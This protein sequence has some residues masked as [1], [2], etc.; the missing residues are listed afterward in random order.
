MAFATVNGAQLFYEISGK[1][2]PIVLIPGLGLDHTYFRYA[3]P[4]LERYFKVIAYDPRGMG[5]SERSAVEYTMELWAED[6]RHLLAHLGIEQA[7]IVGSSL[8]GCVALA[9]LRDAPRIAKSLILLAAFSE[10]DRSAETNFRMRIA[11]VEALGMTEVI[12]DHVLLWTLSREF[13]ETERGKQ[14]ADG[15]LAALSTNDP[16]LY[17]EFLKS[18]LRFGRVMPGQEREPKFTSHLARIDVPTLV[19]VGDKDILTP[20]AFSRKIVERMPRAELSVIKD[21]GH[22]TFIERPEEN[23]RLIVDFLRRQ[24][25]A[26]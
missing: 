3:V 13:I 23:T 4:E 24:P 19:V 1:G 18:I 20:V 12:R 9:L 11:I 17:V 10:L 22:I 14:A 25:G 2:E 16:K 21:C 6:L 8:G 15:L 26:A 7:H 5:R